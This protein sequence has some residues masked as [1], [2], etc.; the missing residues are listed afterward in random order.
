VD[1]EEVRGT[2]LDDSADLRFVE[3]FSTANRGGS[4][5][6]PRFQARFDE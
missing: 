3:E 6:L 2:S 1:E 5:G 4:E